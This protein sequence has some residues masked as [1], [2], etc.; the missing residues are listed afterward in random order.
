MFPED[1]HVSW[2]KNSRL[3]EMSNQRHGEVKSEQAVALL[4]PGLVDT[5]GDVVRDEGR[6]RASMC[7]EVRRGNVSAPISLQHD[8]A[9]TSLSVLGRKRQLDGSRRP[10]R[11]RPSQLKLISMTSSLPAT[12]T[13]PSY[14]AGG[15]DPCGSG[16]YAEPRGVSNSRFYGFI[17]GTKRDERDD[18]ERIRRATHIL[19]GT[20][21]IPIGNRQASASIDSWK[22]R[23][24]IAEGAGL[25]LPCVLSLRKRELSIPG[26]VV[27]AFASNPP[28]RRAGY[29]TTRRSG[30]L[31]ALK[32]ALRQRKV[33]LASPIGIVAER[34]L[35]PVSPRIP[36]TSLINLSL[37]YPPDEPRHDLA[38][39]ERRGSFRKDP[40]SDNP[41]FDRNSALP[42]DAPLRHAAENAMVSEHAQQ[43]S[44]PPRTAS[45]QQCLGESGGEV[46]MD[47]PPSLRDSTKQDREDMDSFTFDFALDFAV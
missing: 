45:L 32:T 35:Q 43:P 18:A 30:T 47:P 38:E 19:S 40:P 3:V 39:G 15:A 10:C 11:G 27:T 28:S 42:L 20:N 16:I 21:N 12:R 1:A 14:W 17:A 34:T 8:Y 13:G 7:E 26:P 24:A 37:R 29:T 2:M 4:A 41:L 6:D 31:G 44:G 23:T 36:P 22:A 33:A 46:N 5:D 9:D 25:V